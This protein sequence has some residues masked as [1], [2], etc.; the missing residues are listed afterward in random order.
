MKDG[1]MKFPAPKWTREMM[2]EKFRWLATTVLD[3]AVVDELLEMAWHVDK[4][5]KVR[6]LTARLS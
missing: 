2:A 4:L 3:L 6:D 1:G 5:N